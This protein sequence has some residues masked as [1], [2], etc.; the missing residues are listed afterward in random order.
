MWQK[1]I[2][3]VGKK[4][5]VERNLAIYKAYQDLKNKS[6]VGRMFGISGVA[7]DKT[8]KRVEKYPQEVIDK[9]LNSTKLDSDSQGDG[10]VG[11]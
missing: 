2:P 5:N 1:S 7:V 4:V 9:F 10:L 3:Q 8:L 11:R 6:R